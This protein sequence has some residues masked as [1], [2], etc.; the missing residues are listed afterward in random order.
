MMARLFHRIKYE[1]WIAGKLVFP[2]EEGS[3]DG[4]TT[5]KASYPEA[6]SSRRC[7]NLPAGSLRHWA[8][9][10]GL[11]LPK[12]AA[13]ERARGDRQAARPTAC[14]Q[15]AGHQW[16]GHAVRGWF[17]WLCA[18]E[19]QHRRESQKES[20]SLQIMIHRNGFQIGAKRTLNAKGELQLKIRCAF[21]SRPR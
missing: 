17:C 8:L 6:G 14:R 18:L 12:A 19:L 20:E 16:L 9:N 1:K 5:E 11:P 2:E 4:R 7:L 10:K 15:R 21:H 13:R 3:C